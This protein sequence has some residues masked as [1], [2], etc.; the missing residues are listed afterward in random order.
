MGYQTAAK[1]DADSVIPEEY[2]G[3]WFL[4][5]PLESDHLGVSVLELEPGAEGQE[6]DETGSGQEEVYY[7]V[8]GEVDVELGERTVTLSSDEAIRLDPDTTRKLHNRGDERA[9]LILVGAPL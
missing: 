2:G 3:M 1:T 8:Q 7:V 5:G 6:H 9:K 4:K